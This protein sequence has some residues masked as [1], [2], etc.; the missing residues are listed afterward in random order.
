MNIILKIYFR[1]ENINKVRSFCGPNVYLSEREIKGE[2]QK[3]ITVHLDP[4]GIVLYMDIL[5][6]LSDMKEKEENDNRQSLAKRWEVAFGKR[7]KT[8][9]V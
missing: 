4:Q 2:I 9:R 7:K 8:C 1:N 6:H 3:F 5:G